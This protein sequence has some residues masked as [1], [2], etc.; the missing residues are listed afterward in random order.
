MKGIT[1]DVLIS[2]SV[3]YDLIHR[4]LWEPDFLEKEEFCLSIN[5]F[6]NFQHSG[7]TYTFLTLLLVEGFFFFCQLA[8]RQIPQNLFYTMY[9]HVTHTHTFLEEPC[10]MCVGFLCMPFEI[11]IAQFWGEELSDCDQH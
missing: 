7:L 1:L 2:L 9:V 8:M 6:L 5:S 4:R 11:I 3:G 10:L